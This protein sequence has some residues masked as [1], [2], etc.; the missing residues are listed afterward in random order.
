VTDTL[1]SRPDPEHPATADAAVSELAAGPPVVRVDGVLGALGDSTRR[2]VV[3]LLA[4]GGGRT[5]TSLAG[6]LPVTRQAIVQHLAVLREAGLVESRRVG[7]D[8]RFELRSEALT[9]TAAWIAD[10]AAQWDR[11]LA[12]IAEIAETTQIEAMLSASPATPESL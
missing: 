6:E 11:R 3:E 10:V 9:K 2:T 1:A 5:A 12:V 7:R 8:V 4:A